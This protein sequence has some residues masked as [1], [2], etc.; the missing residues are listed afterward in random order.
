[1]GDR[2]EV[3]DGASIRPQLH[4]RGNPKNP[5]QTTY[6]DA[7]SIRPRLHSRGNGSGYVD[8]KSDRGLQF[9]RGFIAAET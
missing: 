6:T 4:S 1:M 7:A 8:E 3:V 9:G 5:E 2:F